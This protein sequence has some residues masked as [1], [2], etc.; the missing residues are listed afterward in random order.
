MTAAFEEVM[1][2]RGEGLPDD[3]EVEITGADPVFSTRFKIGE[4]CA[5]VLAGIGVAVSDIW[6]LKVGRRQNAAIDA[7]P[8][9]ATLRS[10]RYLQRP[11]VD[12]AFTRVLNPT[13][14]SALLADAARRSA[15]VMLDFYADWCIP[16][17]AMEARTFSDPK[18]QASLAGTVLLRADVTQNSPDDAA[19]LERFG[20]HGPPAILFFARDGAELER[21]RIV[22]Y[23]D[24]APFTAWATTAVR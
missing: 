22:G 18:V 9:A 16:C 1:E 23:M 6:A 2:I 21:H 12:G 15:P 7:R 24:P 13:A 5:S 14:L 19:L 8:A 10:T 4:T 11:G 17:R 20:L 3:G